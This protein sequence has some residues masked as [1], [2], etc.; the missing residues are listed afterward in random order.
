ML[1]SIVEFEVSPAS[2][3]DVLAFLE[4]EAQAVR[5]FTGNVAYTPLPNG[6]GGN[7]VLLQEWRDA[8]A[9]EAFKASATFKDSNKYLGPMIQG[10]PRSRSFDA[11]LVTS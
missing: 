5:H 3:S 1:I 6:E 8:K 4:V 11:R 2:R 10:A 7:I 9:F